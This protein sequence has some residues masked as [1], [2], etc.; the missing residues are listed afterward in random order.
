MELSYLCSASQR[1]LL[2]EH[3][4]LS[5]KYVPKAFF[6]F[7]SA[8]TCETLLV[9]TSRTQSAVRT[10]THTVKHREKSQAHTNV[11]TKMHDRKK[12]CNVKWTSIFAILAGLGFESHI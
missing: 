3:L 12:T 7:S 6:A 9:R 5:T 8:Q 4:F 2:P 11:Y 10:I 1:T